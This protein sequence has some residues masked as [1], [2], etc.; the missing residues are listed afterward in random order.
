M[1]Q[2]RPD[3]WYW[4]SRWG[5]DRAQPGVAVTI[6]TPELT[7]PLIGKV[8]R[9][10]VC[11]PYAGKCLVRHHV[12]VVQDRPP[13]SLTGIRTVQVTVIALEQSTTSK[14]VP[15]RPGQ[16]KSRRGRSSS[17]PKQ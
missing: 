3:W 15:Q 13:S 10:S 12:E 16:R 7:Q 2:Y 1:G 14:T 6:T 4:S 17:P 8:V 9:Y 5:A 11:A